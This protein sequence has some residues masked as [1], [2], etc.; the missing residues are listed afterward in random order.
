MARLLIAKA[1]AG[2]D[3]QVAKY[4]KQLLPDLD[5]ALQSDSLRTSWKNFWG[6]SI[7]F[8]ELANGV[9][10]HPAILQA[11]NDR[12]KS[13]APLILD[14]IR[15]GSVKGIDSAKLLGTPSTTDPAGHQLAHAGLEHT[16]G[17]LF[18]V[19]KTSYGYKRA[20]WVEGEIEKGFG[21]KPG[22]F[23]PRPESGTLFANV[24]YFT[25]QIAF[26]GKERKLT[27][28]RKGGE[29]LPAELK[30]FDFAKL[31]TTRLEETVEALDPSGA[32]RNVIFRT[33]LV[34]FI[35]PQKNT[36]LLVYSVEDP[37]DGGHVLITAFPVASSFVDTVM[38]PDNLGEGKPVQSRYNA[39]VEGVTGKKLTGVRKK[40]AL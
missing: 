4:L 40:V 13:N 29:R 16:Y 30:S 6:R 35:H 9:I 15:A 20:R 31:N 25:G 19:L 2:Q 26:R 33:D 22:V 3:K 14:N 11:L 12:F 32:K 8:D 21:L 37:S 38:N 10:V 27:S 23:G 17:Y 5:R 36:H 1:D 34:A 39:F 18:S 28:L 7:N 24:T